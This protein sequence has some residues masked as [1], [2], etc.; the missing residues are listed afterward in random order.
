MNIL[1]KKSYDKQWIITKKT[2]AGNCHQI[3]EGV[4]SNLEATPLGA[5]S[6]HCPLTL[7]VSPTSHGID[8]LSFEFYILISRTAQDDFRIGLFHSVSVRMIHVVVYSSSSLCNIL[9][10]EDTMLTRS[11]I[12]GHLGFHFWSIMNFAILVYAFVFWIYVLEWNCW[13]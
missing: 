8:Q 10:H 7:T 1:T 9:V 2:H 5:S 11:T 3:Q 4:A 12:D 13:L 6:R